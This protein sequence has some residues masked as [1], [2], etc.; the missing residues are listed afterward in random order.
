MLDEVE[1]WQALADDPEGEAVIAALPE[2]PG[3]GDLEALR[4]RWSPGVAACAMAV[5]RARG[6]AKGK[7]PAEMAAG[8][9]ADAAGVEMA[10]SLRVARHKAARF[11]VHDDAVDLCCGIG[12]DAIALAEVCGMVLAVDVSPVRAWMTARNAGCMAM[13]AEVEGVGD[14]GE[15]MVAHIDPA[16]RDG[17]GQRRIRYDELEPGP[18][19]IEA[20]VGSRP[21]VAVK[22]PPGIDASDPPAGELEWISEGGRLT[23]AVLWTGSLASDVNRRATLLVDDAAVSITGTGSE[24]GECVERLGRWMHTVDPSVERAGLMGVLSQQSG[25]AMLDPGAGVLTADDRLAGPLVTAFEVLERLPWSRRRVR[26]WLSE[27]DA[28]IVD[29]KTRGRVI[30]ADAEARAL[31]GD[32]AEPFVVFVQRLAGVG[33]PVEAVITRRAE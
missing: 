28:G 8:L 13:C 27:R 14:P 12:G 15:G 30:D 6:K 31:R 29:V 2:T 26:A 3:P 22:L 23:Q 18:E 32:G 17:Q 9:W 7:F 25:G 4:R 1:D 33:A 16:R 20:L 5:S 21:G 10:S 19:V 24:V 11:A